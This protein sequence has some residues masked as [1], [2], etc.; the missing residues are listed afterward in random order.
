CRAWKPDRAPHCDAAPPSASARRAALDQHKPGS[1]V[2]P[3][4]RVVPSDRLTTAQSL[5]A[6]RNA[7]QRTRTSIFPKG[8]DAP[9]IH[10]RMGSS[11]MCQ[12]RTRTPSPRTRDLG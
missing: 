9:L 11:M 5:K 7:E 2:L 6:G 1:E 4:A 10:D 12:A 3:A 8:M